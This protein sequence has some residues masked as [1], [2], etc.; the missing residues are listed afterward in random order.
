[1]FFSLLE[2]APAVQSRG[3]IGGQGD[4]G[5]RPERRF[6]PGMEGGFTAAF[7]VSRHTI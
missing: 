6:K 3:L 2:T 4:A 1:M 5:M 7:L